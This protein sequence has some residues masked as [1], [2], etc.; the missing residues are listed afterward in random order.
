[1]DNS[2]NLV[3]NIT[4]LNESDTVLHGN[5]NV[6]LPQSPPTAPPPSDDGHVS[7]LLQDIF[8]VVITPAISLFGC[9]G[10]VL[11]IIVLIRSRQRMK[12]ADGGRDSGTLLG[13]LVLAVSDML[14]CAAV[15][16]RAF[17]SIG[18]NE[19]LFEPNDFRLYYQV[20]GTGVINTFILTSTWITVAMASMRYKGICHPLSTSKV[21]RSNCVRLIYLI[22]ITTCTLINLPTFWQ[23]KITDF[24]IDGHVYY[25]IDIGDFAL[26]SRKGYIFLWF[27]AL[28]G[29]ISPALLLLY[30]N[31]S[32]IVALR[33]SRSIRREG[34]VRPS[35]S[36]SHNRITRLLVVIVILFIV[37]VFPAEMMDFCLALIVTDPDKTHVFIMIRSI[38]NFLQVVNFSCNF[39][40]YCA[41]NVHFRNTVRE[42]MTLKRRR[43]L[44]R[45]SSSV[46]SASKTES[47]RQTWRRDPL[48]VNIRGNSFQVPSTSSP[49]TS[50]SGRESKSLCSVL[51]SA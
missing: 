10:N 21:R 51:Q 44:V 19:A 18:G 40:V 5:Y 22:T 39:V 20:Y 47:T 17:A 14:F 1:M 2:S 24:Q 50:H 15:F 26:N 11:N 25:L 8:Y 27:R 3:G 35:V 23:Y 46:L 36:R 13:L 30:C 34:R 4:I 38:A 16:P 28:V 32:L 37:L 48:H 12:T 43:L 29:I 41:L 7:Y 42:V 9:I 49:P 6:L 45:R 31:C 33:R